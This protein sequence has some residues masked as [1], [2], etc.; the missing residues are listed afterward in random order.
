M[1]KGRSSRAFRSS[2]A[3][4]R[5]VSA[6]IKPLC[7]R[8]PRSVPSSCSSVRQRRA[9]FARELAQSVKRGRWASLDGLV[10]LDAGCGKGRYTR[11]LAEHL[12]ALAALD[13][14]SAVE[15]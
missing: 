9:A 11:F 5:V 3:S 8:T 4:P 7:W 12:G 13:G 6:T 2:A 15:A 10:G 14:S 1:P